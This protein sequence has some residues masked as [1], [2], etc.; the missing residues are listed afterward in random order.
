MEEF[1]EGGGLRRDSNFGADEGAGTAMD[2][3]NKNVTKRVD[4]HNNKCVH[5]YNYN[6]FSLSLSLSI[7]THTPSILAVCGVDTGKIS[8]TQE[9][10]K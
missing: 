7:H 1:T 6:Q 8:W 3:S 9:Q 2:G 10:K 4:K 5:V